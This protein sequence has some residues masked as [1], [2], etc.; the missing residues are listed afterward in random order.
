MRTR[1]DWQSARLLLGDANFLKNLYEYD[2]DRIPDSL[3]KKLKKY[4]D[5]P[6]FTPEAVEKVSRVG[7]VVW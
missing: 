4:I 1:S 5:N 2:K 7:G 3:I 6:K